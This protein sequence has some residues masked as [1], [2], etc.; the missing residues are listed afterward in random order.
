MLLCVVTLVSL[1]P[2]LGAPLS[3]TAKA[4]T[5]SQ[6]NI[7][8][9]ADYLYDAVWVCKKTVNGWRNQYTFYAGNTYRMPYGQPVYAGKY[10]GYG[11]SVDD[12]L[13]AAANSGS[14][15]YTSRSNYA[16][17]YSTYYATDCSAFVSWCWG[18]SRQTTATIPNYSTYL[19]KTNTTNVYKLQLGD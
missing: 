8:A 18:I 15:F 3:L 19:G 17:K 2:A 12:Y 11:V 13:S 1:L 5:T 6:N 9:R 14:A 10:I 4:A 7:V 16:G